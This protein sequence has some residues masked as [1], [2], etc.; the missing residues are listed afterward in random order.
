MNAEGVFV[1]GHVPGLFSQVD[2]TLAPSGWTCLLGP[3]GAGKSTLLRLLAGLETG[4]NFQGR[5]SPLA[6]HVAFMAQQSLLL[7]WASVLDNVMLGARLRHERPDPVQARALIA[8]VG[9]AG[10]E[11]KKPAALSGGEA[12]RVALARTLMEDRPV[13]LL[14]EPFSALDAQTRAE[15]QDLAHG[16]LR[17]RSVLLVTH[18]P[19]EAARL[20]DQIVVL[21]EAGL[22]H[23]DVPAG[24]APRPV[25]DGDTLAAQG[26]LFRQLRRAA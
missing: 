20:A 18:D 8:Q 13:V 21:T 5:V 10:H 23:V 25:D 11:S 1:S 26:R 14:D 12:Q 3:S 15:M 19:A 9:L 7:P 16:M 22:D 24:P 2:L 4:V 17:G 6:G